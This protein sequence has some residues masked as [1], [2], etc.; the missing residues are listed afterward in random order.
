MERLVVSFIDLDHFSQEW[1]FKAKGQKQVDL[2]SLERK[3]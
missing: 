2:F 3:N 1:T